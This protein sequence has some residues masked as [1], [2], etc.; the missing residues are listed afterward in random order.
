MNSTVVSPG[1]ISIDVDS[2]DSVVELRNRLPKQIIVLKEIRMQFDTDANSLASGVLYLDMPFIS[3]SHITENTNG[4]RMPV[5]L[6]NARVTLRQLELPIDMSED[7]NF[8]FRLI[9]S[10]KDG[11]APTGF[12]RAT[13]VFTH[14]LIEH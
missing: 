3:S 2:V 12:Q 14:G 1:I 8:N 11:T 7:I 13:L 5:L 9:I 6:E 4:Y 10:K